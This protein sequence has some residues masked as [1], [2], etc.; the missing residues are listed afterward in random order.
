MILVPENWHGSP[1]ESMIWRKILM[2]MQIP[3]QIVHRAARKTAEA[4]IAGDL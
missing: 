3:R 1:A 2:A 4:G